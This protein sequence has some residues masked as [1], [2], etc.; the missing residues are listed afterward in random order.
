MKDKESKNPFEN[1]PPCAADYIKLIIQKMKWRKKVLE[2]VQAELIA[3]FEDALRECKTNEEKEKTANKIIENFGDAELIAVLARR[4]KKRCRPL[5]QKI[6][7]RCFQVIGIIIIYLTICGI[8]VSWGKPNITVNYVEWLNEN[9]RKD[10]DESLNSAPLIKE[11]T[12]LIVPMP[13]WLAD[14]NA[15]W[16]EDFNQIRLKEFESWL[17]Q[18]SYAINK[19]RKAGEKPFYWNFY[20]AN[21]PDFIKMEFF[22]ALVDEFPLYRKLA[23]IVDWQ[24]R[25]SV[26][27]NNLDDAIEDA[28]LLYKYGHNMTG[29]GLLVEQLVGIA[30]EG[31][32]N[33]AITDIISREDLNSQ[34]LLK[35]QTFLEGYQYDNLID[36]GAEKA[37]LYDYVQRNFSDDG[38][39]GGKPIRLGL[40]FAG[41]NAADV[42]FKILTFN[43][44]DKKDV[45]REI[46]NVYN[47]IQQNFETLQDDITYH[48]N[49]SMMMRMIIPAVGSLEKTIWQIKIK[50]DALITILAI[51]R[52]KQE[53]GNYPRSLNDLKPAYIDEIPS[54]IYRQGPMTYKQTET[55]FILYS[56]GIDRDDDGGKM[57]KSECSGNPYMWNEK[58]GDA[59]F[60]PVEQYSG[61]K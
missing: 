32:G 47:T 33:N 50:R 14:S 49:A 60:W 29:N 40:S 10:R 56:F 58:D 27:V 23:Q 39:N 20:D 37:F 3:H 44:P 30:I 22:T 4:A 35:I 7:I 61:K 17:A 53:T 54:D 57:G 15:N 45:L 31:L 55:G 36:L 24:V 41:K 38:G 8:Y 5:W 2:D 21:K 51:L 28:L 18:N 9:V 25:Y 46:E 19:F 11:A 52:F 59:V 43:L 6:L 13:P 26:Y 16:P 42:I 1:L 12:K 48:N 34:Q